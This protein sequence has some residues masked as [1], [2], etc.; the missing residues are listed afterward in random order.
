VHDGLAL[1]P[2]VDERGFVPRDLNGEVAVVRQVEENLVGGDIE[3]RRDEFVF[4][5]LADDRVLDGRNDLLAVLFFR[6][7][8][9]LDAR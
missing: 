7:R 9:A 5:V 8:R 6:A 1:A 3:R 4:E 2:G